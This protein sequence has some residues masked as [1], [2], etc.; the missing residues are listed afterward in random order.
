MQ[1]IKTKKKVQKLQEF[2]VHKS[3]NHMQQHFLK[4][5][6]AADDMLVKPSSHLPQ[7]LVTR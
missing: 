7:D 3:F 6:C 4:I 1:K 5:N 2:A